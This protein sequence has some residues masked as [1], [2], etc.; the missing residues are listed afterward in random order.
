MVTIVFGHENLEAREKLLQT[1]A[2]QFS[3]ISSLQ[4]IINEKRNDSIFDQEVIGYHGEDHLKEKLGE[5]VFK[6]GPKSFFQTNTKQARILY[7][8]AIEA[9]GLTGKEN[10]YD[11]YTGIGSIALYIAH[12]CH[13]VVGIEEV[14]AAIEDAHANMQLN[15]IGNATF[16]AGDV[17]DILTTEF[18][19]KHGLPDIVITDPPRAGM[20]AQVVDMLLTLEAPKIIYI[21]CNPSTQARDLALLTQKYEVESVQAVDMFPHTHHIESVASLRLK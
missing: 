19:E 1:L 5:V 10:V 4:Y 3:E 2:N 17:K 16:Y 21:S 7:D 14:E 6:I 8:T 18:S 15:D 11:L 20:H 9:A 13:H 12:R